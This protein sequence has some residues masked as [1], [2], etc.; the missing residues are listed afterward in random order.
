MGG[1]AFPSPLDTPPIDPLTSDTSDY[2]DGSSAHHVGG[3][4]KT[5]SSKLEKSDSGKK[6]VWRRKR[7]Q[8]LCKDDKSRDCG[9]S[10]KVSNSNQLSRRESLPPLNSIPLS[11]LSSL[12]PHLGQPAHFDIDV[13]DGEDMG[14]E[15]AEFPSRE[16]TPRPKHS[17]TPISPNGT[18]SPEVTALI[19]SVRISFRR[20]H[21][22]SG[23]AGSIRAQGSGSSFSKKT[24][25][26]ASPLKTQYQADPE[27]HYN[28]SSS[29][30]ESNSSRRGSSSEV[31]FS[32]VDAVFSDSESNN[33]NSGDS[34]I[35]MQNLIS[36][37]RFDVEEGNGESVGV[38][39]NTENAPHSVK[40]LY[41]NESSMDTHGSDGEGNEADGESTSDGMFDR[42]SGIEPNETASP[43][44]A[45]SDEVTPC[46]TPESSDNLASESHAGVTEIQNLNPNCDSGFPIEN[47]NVRDSCSGPHEPISSRA[48]YNDP[49]P[50]RYPVSDHNIL[51]STT[52]LSG[53]WFEDMPTRRSPVH[54]MDD[55]TDDS[56]ADIESTGLT[57]LSIPVHIRRVMSPERNDDGM[58]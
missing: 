6:K 28:V 48:I 46:S 40:D 4:N 7:R 26:E 13:E 29:K 49:F 39:S 56:D 8:S 43:S 37:L 51:T 1:G 20:T 17:G 15:G 24:S 38:A 12:P 31:P 42:F 10:E 16:S 2:Q 11:P 45:E 5:A 34:P 21:R 32:N 50:L 47:P 30:E 44:Q 3:A 14:Q 58:R 33:E 35:P 53:E 54:T 25:L 19:D 36:T 52:L 9:F 41:S 57:G 22:R 18:L 55:R 23:S 27:H